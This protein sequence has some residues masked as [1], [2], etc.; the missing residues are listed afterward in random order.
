MKIQAYKGTRDFYPETMAVRNWLTDIWRRVSIRHGFEEYDG[1][2]FEYLDLYTA[3][4]GQG[5]VE[6]LFH[7]TDRG[8]REL[9][10][11]PEIT[12][13]LARMVNARANTLPRPIKWFSVP[14]LCRAE[15][16]QRGRL[17]EF[18]QWNL[19][20][21]GADDLLAD[22][23][24]ILAAIDC[25]REVGLTADDVVVKINDRRFIGAIF[26]ALAIPVDRHDA[27]YAAIDKAAKIPLEAVEEIWSAA[28]PTI[29]FNHIKPLLAIDSRQAL[30]AS[31][32]PVL[33]HAAVADALATLDELF[34]I[35]QN[36]GVADF[37]RFDA[38]I[39]RGL[40][41][42]TGPVYEA[43]DRRQTLRAI[44]GGGR[45]DNL[46]AILGGPKL[47]GT[48]MGM[49]DPVL[50]ELLAERNK[51]PAFARAVDLFLIDADESLFPMILQVAATLRAQGHSVEFNYK[52]QPV[53]R[54]FKAAAARGAGRCAVFGQETR[55]SRQVTVKDMNT[56]HQKEVP[57]DAFLADPNL[58][59]TP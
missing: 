5:I 33:T 53:A 9:A 11:R 8:D 25:L 16:P 39:V 38:R 40:A 47:S 14:R 2:I 46:L 3:K 37:C 7:F 58:D 28:I 18:F 51:I 26:H 17:R 54:H 10:V 24:C 56:G 1:P 50:L 55:S 32:W 15:K 31:G 35:L 59:L 57:L 41:Y 44:L 6:E 27:A 13:T 21:L 43:F 52:R 19:D 30:A 22:A 29:P 4:S 36:F 45:Y 49:G 23:E 20:I 42:Y 48:G 34:A 12:P